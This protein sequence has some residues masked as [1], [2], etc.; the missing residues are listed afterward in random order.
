MAPSTPLRLEPPEKPAK[1][2]GH[3]ADC[4]QAL[5]I[6]SRAAPRSA[7]RHCVESIRGAMVASEPR[8]TQPSAVAGRRYQSTSMALVRLKSLV[9]VAI[10]IGHVREGSNP[11]GKVSTARPVSGRGFPAW[12]AMSWKYFETGKR[13]SI[14]PPG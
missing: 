5:R 13:I 1:A 10:R 2:T 6:A 3:R 12:E 7:S 14:L 8:T 9:E 4:G 11:G